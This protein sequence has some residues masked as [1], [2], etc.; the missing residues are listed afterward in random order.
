MC[1]ALFISN[2]NSKMAVDVSEDSI[3]DRPHFKDFLNEYDRQALEIQKKL[4]LTKSQFNHEILDWFS[5]LTLS[6][7]LPTVVEL[8]TLQ[9]IVKT[10]SFN[11]INESTLKAMSYYLSTHWSKMTGNV[12]TVEEILDEV[13]PESVL[14][15]EPYQVR[16]FHLMS[17]Q[18]ESK[19][20]KI[21]SSSKTISILKKVLP[22]SLLAF[23]F[24][25]L[26]GDAISGALVGYMVSLGSE[27]WNHR[28]LM[29][30]GNSK[31]RLPWF[32]HN[33]VYTMPHT[34]MMA[35]FHYTH[36]Q[37]YTPKKYAPGEGAGD[38]N[39]K[40]VKEEVI[41]R[42]IQN[43]L[44]QDGIEYY[45]KT[46]KNNINYKYRETIITT[47][48]VT[49]LAAILGALSTNDPIVG[50]VMASLFSYSALLHINITHPMMH[51][52]YTKSMNKFG[53]LKKWFLNSSYFQ[54]IARHHYGHHVKP[55]TNFHALPLGYDKLLNTEYQLTNKDL[56]K[57]LENDYPF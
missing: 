34:L 55:N 21:G 26:G 11:N 20:L 49:P 38:L 39:S 50:G 41:P 46:T 8:T 9:L 15:K 18:I 22:V 17:H 47:L 3:I 24:S 32:V 12:R 30:S 33:P 53:S 28:W 57:M 7:R 54:F 29:H 45:V 5:A 40:Y 36:H 51:E 48:T 43:G 42:L 31:E 37:E 35:Q 44:D 10:R 4:S 19:T 23:A 56:I 6:N 1:N 25:K 27:Y 14:Q 2:S 13:L 16:R 52:T